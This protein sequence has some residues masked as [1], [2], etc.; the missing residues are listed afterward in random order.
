MNALFLVA[1]L[2]ASDFSLAHLDFEMS[3]DTYPYGV[4]A[5]PM[6]RMKNG[7]SPRIDSLGTDKLYGHLKDQTFVWNR[8]GVC[9]CGIP[10][11]DLEFTELFY[12]Y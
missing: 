4:D 3:C 7:Q 9:E 11:F 6:V 12:D 10:T 2:T 1:S 5:S 8:K